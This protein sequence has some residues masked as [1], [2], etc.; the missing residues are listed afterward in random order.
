[1]LH[2]N[3]FLFLIVISFQPG[4]YNAI[5]RSLEMCFWFITSAFIA[6][7]SDKKWIRAQIIR[8]F[9]LYSWLINVCQ[10]QAE[11][12]DNHVPEKKIKGRNRLFQFSLNVS[13]LLKSTAGTSNICGCVVFR[14]KT[15]KIIWCHLRLTSA[16]R[17]NTAGWH[18]G[19]YSWHSR[20]LS[21]R[22][23]T[24]VFSCGKWTVWSSNLCQNNRPMHF[25]QHWNNGGMQTSLSP[26]GV[27]WLR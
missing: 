8:A 20:S 23:W 7:V 24:M 14:G 3:N 10:S 6:V 26:L 16:E 12:F 22:D 5:F 25:F 11:N 9:D 13:L 2:W 1:M 4:I 18:T 21:W 17:H 19:D 15:D 27:I